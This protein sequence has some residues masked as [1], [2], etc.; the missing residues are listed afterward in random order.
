MSTFS[1]FEFFSNGFVVEN[2]SMTETRYP[3]VRACRGWGT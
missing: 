2:I 3:P 1:R